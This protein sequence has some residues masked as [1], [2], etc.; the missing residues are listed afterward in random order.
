[1]RRMQAPCELRIVPYTGHLFEESGA[2]AHVARL[3]GEWFLKH[4]K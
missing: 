2:L 3:A 4:L 1:M